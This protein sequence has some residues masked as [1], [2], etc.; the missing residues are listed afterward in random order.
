MPFGAI[1][2]SVVLRI[3]FFTFAGFGYPFL[4]VQII[5]YLCVFLLSSIHKKRKTAYL[6]SAFVLLILF[7][8]LNIYPQKIFSTRAT[9]SPLEFYNRYSI[10]VHNPD[11]CD[12]I[13]RDAILKDYKLM[14]ISGCSNFINYDSEG[15][16]LPIYEN[17]APKT[18]SEDYSFSG[19]RNDGGWYM[20]ELGLSPSSPYFSS[21]NLILDLIKEEAINTCKINAGSLNVQTSK[22]E[23]SKC[24]DFTNQK[25]KHSCYSTVYYE[26]YSQK[27]QKPKE[28]ALC[29]SIQDE[30]IQNACYTDV[31]VENKN[32]S[33]C[34]DISKVSAKKECRSSLQELTN[35]GE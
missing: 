35:T 7:V 21:C 2:M 30:E 4:F 18:L 9:Q 34:D 33:I 31:A 11:I 29:S 26:E 10:F 3:P 24:A 22:N 27:Y 15:T 23:F 32:I 20:K 6:P 25:E 28:P 5:F 14:H 12:G 16:P 1:A 17:V 13:N 19:F 8:L